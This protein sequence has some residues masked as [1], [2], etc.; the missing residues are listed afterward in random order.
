MEG[1]INESECKIKQTDLEFPQNNEIG[2]G[3]FKDCAYLTS[4]SFMPVITE[5]GNEAFEG[6]T[7][8]SIISF[9][10]TVEQWKSVDKGADWHKNVP[11]DVVHCTDGNVKL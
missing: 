7:S 8:L 11:I 9:G 5:I 10:G 1:I 2:R 4:I 6:C 3:A